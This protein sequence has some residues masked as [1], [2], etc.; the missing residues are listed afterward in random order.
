[1]LVNLETIVGPAVDGKYGVAGFNVFGWE[2]AVAVTRGAEE[3]GAPVILSASLDYTN[4]VPVEVIAKGF[5][6][7]AEQASVPV[8]AHLDHCYELD[9]VKRAI[10]A[11]MTSVMYDGSQ[12]PVRDNIAGTRRIVEYGRSANVS[13][14]A[15]IGS[16]PYAEGRDHI[17][18][19]KTDV[20]EAVRLAEESGLTA[21]AVSVGNVHRLRE[22]SAKIDFDLLAEIENRTT[23][24]LVIHGTSGIDPSDLVALSR[25]RVAKFNVGTSLRRSFGNGMRQA[26]AADPSRF[27]RLQIMN[28][29]IPVMAEETARVIRLL[30]WTGTRRN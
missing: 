24:P 11:G 13:V 8:C 25:T 4:F 30:G 27:D 19:E 17:R 12:L 3:I 28:E 1:M 15:E 5:R 18:A 21:M 23:V 20:E 6:I 7:L 16:V 14:E 2:D 9:N 29:V 22:P 26:L 10:D